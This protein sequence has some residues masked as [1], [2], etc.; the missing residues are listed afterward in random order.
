MWHVEKCLMKTRRDS[1]MLLH[2]VLDRTTRMQFEINCD[3]K[4]SKRSPILGL[5]VPSTAKSDRF[6]SSQRH[7]VVY[8][9]VKL[10]NYFLLILCTLLIANRALIERKINREVNCDN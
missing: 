9:K 3:P 7:D 1:A 2:G 5:D 10:R 6:N 8:I 4:Y